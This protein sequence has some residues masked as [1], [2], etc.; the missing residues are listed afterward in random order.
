MN[1]SLLLRAE[2]IS[3][4]KISEI[5]FYNIES[6]ENKFKFNKEPVMAP[7]I[8]HHKFGSI[9]NLDYNIKLKAHEINNDDYYDIQKWSGSG[10]IQ[11]NL[12]F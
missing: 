4:N 8:Y 5:E 3:N 12:I 6:L 11:K 1:I 9:K 2:K 10:E 7:F